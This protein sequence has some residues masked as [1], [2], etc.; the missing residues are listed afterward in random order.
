V[1]QYLKAPN[2]H[3]GDDFGSALALEG[4]M[5]VVTAQDEDGKGI[6]VDPVKEGGQAESGAAYVFGW[7]GNIWKPDT[8]LKAPQSLLKIHFGF[9]AS[10]ELPWL[11]VSTTDQDGGRVHFFERTPEK[12]IP[13]PTAQPFHPEY[14]DDFG[15][16]V[17]LRGDTLVV[18]AWY[19]SS[20]ATGVEGEG[21]D[22][23]PQ[24]DNSASHAGAAYVFERVDGAW[25]QSAY[26]KASN[27]DAGDVFGCALAFDGNTIAIG[28]RREDSADQGTDGVG[29]DDGAGNSGAVYVFER[30]GASW[31]QTAYLKSSNSEAGDEF[32]AA[33]A[34]SGDTLVVGARFEDSRYGAGELDNGAKDSGAVYVFNRVGSSWTQTAYLKASNADPTDF[35]GTRVALSGDRLAVSATYEAGPSNGSANSGA[36]YLFERDGDTWHETDYFRAPEPAQDDFFGLDLVLDDKTLVVGALGEDK[37]PD[38]PPKTAPDSGAAY[39]FR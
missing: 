20:A 9:A 27:T 8:Y 12:W 15:R 14:G 26:L 35:F 11:A 10:L 23:G 16:F 7:N 6:G 1:P 17:V 4:D 13:G 2:A 19:E 39:V 34:L 3:D 38:G 31:V 30:F 36:V 21:A 29:E 28:A 22:D 33:V 18:T 25:P 24:L 37:H 32:G 5:L